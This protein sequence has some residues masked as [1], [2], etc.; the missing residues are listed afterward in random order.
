MSTNSTGGLI[1][2]LSSAAGTTARIIPSSDKFAVWLVFFAGLITVLKKAGV[3]VPDYAMYFAVTLGVA[4]LLYE[5]SASKAIIR[6]WYFAKPGALVA[7][8]LIW[9]CAFG[10]SVNNWMGAASESQAEKTNL[11]QTSYNTYNTNQDTLKSAKTELTRLEGRMGWMETAVNGKPVRT[12][13]AAQADIDNAKSNRYWTATDGCKETK[14]KQTR[15]FCDAYR[16]AE[17]EKGLA[18]EKATLSEELKAAKEAYAGASNVALNTKAETSQARGDLMI[19]TDWFGLDEAK[20]QTINGL[21][22]IIA[23]S[24]FL[25]FGSMRA[26]MERLQAEG[27]PRK[28]FNFW[29]KLRRFM[30]KLMF[31]REPGDVRVIKETYTS[32]DRPAAEAMLRAA[33]GTAYAL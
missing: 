25:S 31:G 24:I 27:I 3:N 2:G 13:E 32:T 7:S 29:L 33:H 10:Y 9:G 11:H 28:S 14:G 12:I 15:A 22:A 8:F 19:L 21:G 4:A 30:T 20:A 23:V 5:M 18:I 16:N 1:G 17:A 6:A 26:E